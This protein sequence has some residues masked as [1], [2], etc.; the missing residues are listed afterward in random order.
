[1]KKG[2]I[3]ADAGPIFSLAILDKLYLLD[4]LFNEVYI[5]EAVWREI[6]LKQ[7]TPFYEII[8][9]YFKEK[10]KYITQFNDLGFILDYGESESIILYQE[11]HADFLL[12]DDKKARKFA[13]NLNINCIGTLGLLTQAKI[14]GTVKEL[15]PLFIKL[16]ENKRYYSIDVLNQILNYANEP[17]I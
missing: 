4:V 13:E 10:V 9:S 6:T 3:I 11:L 16:I 7:N 1:M 17:N 12:I 2:I 15:R 14:L 8:Y 5:S